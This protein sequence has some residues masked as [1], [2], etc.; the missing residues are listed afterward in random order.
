VKIVKCYVRSASRLDCRNFF[1]NPFPPRFFNPQYLLEFIFL[2][3]I[4]IGPLYQLDAGI[5]VD[6]LNEKCC[7]SEFFTLSCAR[8]PG[9]VIEEFLVYQSCAIEHPGDLLLINK[10]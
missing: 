9:R 10:Q 2:N 7:K 8:I 5:Q 4:F 6:F 3:K 1:I